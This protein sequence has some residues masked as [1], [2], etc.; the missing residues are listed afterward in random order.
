[1]VAVDRGRA[2]VD[3]GDARWAAPFAG[4]LRDLPVVGDFVAVP[5][6]GPV[7]AILPRRGVIVR[8]QGRARQVLAANVDLALIATSLNRDFNRRR[9]LRFIAIATR[10]DVEPVVLLTKTDLVDEVP[11]LDLGVQTVAVSVVTGAGLDAVAALLAPRRTAVLLGTSGVG[12]STLVNVLLGTERQRVQDIREHDQR[13]RHTTVRRELFELPGGALL[14]DTP[15]LRLVA[16]VEEG[17][18]VEE[19]VDKA[20]LARE[21]RA[22][23]RQMSRAARRMYRERGY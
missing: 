22:R 16:P 23:A 20:A 2:A 9:L 13:G 12:K 15:G 3:T 11:E 21:R 10:G 6:G 17:E 19:P 8:R 14:I 5:P 1:V 7:R 4:R 18:D